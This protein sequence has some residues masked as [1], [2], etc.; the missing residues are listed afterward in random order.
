MRL[1]VHVDQLANAFK[2]ADK[3]FMLEPND[4]QWSLQEVANQMQAECKVLPTVEEIITEL[5]NEVRKDD[6]ILILSNGSFGG[7]SAKLA[8]QLSNRE[9]SVLH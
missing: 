1:G 9:S 3:V 7:L 6:N 8:L 5:L 2:D 4:L